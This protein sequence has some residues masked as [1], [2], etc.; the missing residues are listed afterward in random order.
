MCVFFKVM[1]LFLFCFLL[2]DVFKGWQH[3]PTP[4][5]FNFCARC[6]EYKMQVLLDRKNTIVKEKEN[7]SLYFF[8]QTKSGIIC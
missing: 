5:N 4:Q 7:Q 6:S 8:P 2:E 3:C 1:E